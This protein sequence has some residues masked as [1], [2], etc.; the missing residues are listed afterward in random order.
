[1]VIPPVDQRDAN[2]GILQRSRRRKSA[3]AAA[4]DDDMRL[5]HV[6]LVIESF[7]HHVSPS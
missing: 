4:D 5:V 2:G 3:E 1:V 7:V 6:R